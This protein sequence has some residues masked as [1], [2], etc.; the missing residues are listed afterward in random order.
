MQWKLLSLTENWT[1]SIL[2]PFKLCPQ[3]KADGCF[4]KIIAVQQLAH[5]FKLPHFDFWSSG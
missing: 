3:Y 4:W 5:T 2:N 1:R